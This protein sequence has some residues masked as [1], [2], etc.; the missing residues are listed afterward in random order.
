[1]VGQ[2]NKSLG[3]V[4]W[5]RWRYVDLEGEEDKCHVVQME[6]LVAGFEEI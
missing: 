1:M 6:A 5:Q 2:H 3:C 4:S